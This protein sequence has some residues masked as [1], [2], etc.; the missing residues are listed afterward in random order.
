MLFVTLRRFVHLTH[1]AL[2]ISYL[3]MLCNYSIPYTN[4]TVTSTIADISERLLNVSKAYKCEATG[5]SVQS[6]MSCKVNYELES[7]RL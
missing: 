1:M 6:F 2:C 4:D 3:Y 5:T 7:P